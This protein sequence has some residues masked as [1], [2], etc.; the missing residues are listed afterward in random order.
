[1]HETVRKSLSVNNYL[2][3]RAFENKLKC[4]FSFTKNLYS[5]KLMHGLIRMDLSVRQ[6]VVWWCYQVVPALCHELPLGAEIKVLNLIVTVFRCSRCAT[7]PR[8]SQ[9]LAVMRVKAISC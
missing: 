1:M 6:S 7:A 5:V 3:V 8:V 4:D 2:C 9:Q